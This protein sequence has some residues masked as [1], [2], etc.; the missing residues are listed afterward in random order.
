MAVYDDQLVRL[1]HIVSLQKPP[2]CQEKIVLAK[3]DITVLAFL[4][5]LERRMHRPMSVYGV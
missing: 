4:C 1:K 3:C 2:Y 5:R